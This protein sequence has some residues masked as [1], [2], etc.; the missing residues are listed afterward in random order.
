MCL[1]KNDSENADPKPDE[2][3]NILITCG[4]AIGAAPLAN[5]INL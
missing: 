4:A 2:S 5:S 3:E 1:A